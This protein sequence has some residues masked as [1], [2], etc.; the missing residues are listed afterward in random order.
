M[1]GMAGM[2]ATTV[3]RGTNRIAHDPEDATMNTMYARIWPL[4]TGRG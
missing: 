3:M 2:M 1:E 4:D